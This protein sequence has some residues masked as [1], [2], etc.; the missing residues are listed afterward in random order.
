[1]KT[2]IRA[3]AVATLLGATALLAGCPAGAIPGMV[4]GS[5]APGTMPSGFTGGASCTATSPASTP[6]TG[7]AGLGGY[8]GQLLP[9]GY[10]NAYKTE[11][12]VTA[13]IM[14]VKNETTNW[15][16]FQK[17][18]MGAIVVFKAKM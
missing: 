11:A 16:C 12:E 9:M 10:N 15:E 2:M 13:A 8:S 1:M 4:G 17:F 18:Y 14:K 6:D 3:A 7:A 5:A